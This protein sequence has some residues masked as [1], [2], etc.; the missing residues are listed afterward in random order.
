MDPKQ[1]QQQIEQYATWYHCAGDSVNAGKRST[2][3]TARIQIR[4]LLPPQDPCNDCGRGLRSQR[5][6]TMQRRLD[7]NEWTERCNYCRQYRNPDSG[8]FD[9]DQTQALDVLRKK[10]YAA[11]RAYYGN[12]DTD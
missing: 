10:Y 12:Q 7:I 4:E 2:N 5:T 11:K 1:F 6:V 9:L 3:P 8:E